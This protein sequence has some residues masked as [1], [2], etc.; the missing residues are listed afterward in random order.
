MQLLSIGYN[1]SHDSSFSVERPTGIDSCLFL[2]IKTPGIF[3][4][5]GKEHKVRAN[6]FVLFLNDFPHSYYADGQEY[7]DDW[8][9]FFADENDLRFFRSLHIP[10]NEVVPLH[11][12]H[13]LTQVM[14]LMTYEF[15]AENIHKSDVL[16]L[17]FKLF[18]HKVAQILY[19]KN[20]RTIFTE[21]DHFERMHAL[22]E[23]IYYNP[24]IQR[25]VDSMA[26][27][28]SMSR[29]SFQHNYKKVFGTSV[30]NDIIESRLSKVKFY[31]KTTPM[32]LEE[33][34]YQTGYN[35][36]LHLIRQFKQRYGMT[37]SEYR[38]NK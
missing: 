21:S 14:R 20:A 34:A 2:I 16:E 29:S 36:Q 37:P 27:Q 19:D 1:H 33:I 28:L 25:T 3:K 22:R 11:D 18:F 23:D 7:T 31:L 15:Y 10:I 5:N 35:S 17:Y 32:R 12:I 8:C 26:E 30:T 9:H 24:Q 4:Y 6:S 38:N 13:P